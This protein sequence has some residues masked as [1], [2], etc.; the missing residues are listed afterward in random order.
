MEH[1]ADIQL[2]LMAQSL[3]EHISRANEL[4]LGFAAQ[5]LAMAVMEITIRVHGISHQEIDALCACIEAKTTGKAK[6][7]VALVAGSRSHDRR[8]RARRSRVC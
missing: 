3:Q 1:A 6:Q 8:S 2:K 4:N 7:G 5:L